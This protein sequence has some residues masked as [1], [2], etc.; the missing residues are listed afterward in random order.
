MIALYWYGVMI[1]IFLFNCFNIVS[2]VDINSSGSPH[3][4]GITSSDPS[5]LISYAENHYEINGGIQ[6]NGN[7]FHSFGQF[8]IHSQESAVFNDAGIVNTI[9]RITGQDY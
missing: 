6:K 7:L 4:H 8:N 1:F 9:G 5:T 3:P 2:A